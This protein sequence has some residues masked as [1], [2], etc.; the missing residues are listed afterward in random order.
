MR[1]ASAARL[2]AKRNVIV[3][4]IDTS[5]YAADVRSKYEGF[6]ISDSVVSLGGQS[7]A[8]GAYGFGFSLMG[9][10]ESWTFQEI[11]FFPSPPQTIKT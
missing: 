11:R 7:L 9:N 5:G 10:S 3:G 2:G 1:E 4:L 6:L 8:T